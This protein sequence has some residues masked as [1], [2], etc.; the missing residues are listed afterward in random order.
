MT[1][2]TG[3]T[4]RTLLLANPEGMTERELS[5]ASG[6]SQGIVLAALSRGYGFYVADWVLRPDTDKDYV[7]VW[8]CVPV[9][10]SAVRKYLPKAMQSDDPKKAARAA[11]QFAYRAKHR[12][13]QLDRELEASRLKYEAE[14]LRIREE[15]KAQLEAK[16]LEREA[17]KIEKAAARAKAKLAKLPAAAPA[18]YIPQKT[19][20]VFPPPWAN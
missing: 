8:R 13:A 1:K 5:N 4:L 6:A 11:Y 12:N 3:E 18:G 16:R 17:S 20:W 9:P 7:A 14:R 10:T 2:T 19:Q 15:K